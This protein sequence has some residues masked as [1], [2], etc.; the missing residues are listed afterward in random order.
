MLDIETVKTSIENKSIDDKLIIFYC[1]Y[2]HFI[3]YQYVTEIAKQKNK[4][5]HYLESIPTST[6]SAFD[7]FGTQDI[8]DDIR[9]FS[10]EELISTNSQLS[11]EKN[12]YVITSKIDK[13][14]KELFDEYIVEIPKLETWQIKDYVYSNT[15]GIDPKN[16]DWLIEV[17]QGDI[18]RIDN[19][20][21]KIKLFSENEQKYL[22]D[23][24]KSEGA[25]RDVSTF[26][27]FNITNAITSKD[28][29][30]L[31]NSLREIKS[32]D[33]E[34]LGVVTLLY[35]GFRK[36]IQV[37]LA[38]NPTP[39]NTGLKPNV[40]YA[41]NKSPRVYNKNQ[42]LKCFLE[43]TDIDR[44]LKTGQ[45]EISWLIDYTICKILTC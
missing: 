35:Q 36:L 18:N 28:M 5:I 37:W 40:I 33:A 13:K 20:L 27:V 38:K 21:A 11:E 7:L 44:K 16:L 9:V 31:L 6:S 12:L 15:E 19:E 32:I 22:F 24:M 4:R 26:N 3:A 25:F 30:S 34:P 41:I 14:T 1:K 17:C 43:M 42:L 23:S 29:T 39:D 8:E 10:C 45:I 2:E